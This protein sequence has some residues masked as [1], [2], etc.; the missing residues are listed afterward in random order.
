M[1]DRAWH[2]DGGNVSIPVL[3]SAPTVPVRVGIS[4]HGGCQRGL[5]SVPPA[6]GLEH[7]LFTAFKRD[8]RVLEFAVESSARAIFTSWSRYRTRPRRS[9]ASTVSSWGA[10]ESRYLL[11]WHCLFLECAGRGSGAAARRSYGICWH[12]LA[13]R[14]QV[15]DKIL[16]LGRQ[17]PRDARRVLQ[18]FERF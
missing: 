14:E 12:Q 15:R 9:V 10:D 2:G 1:Q 7:T 11:I 5:C 3:R 4:K 8:F 13:P 6:L 18:L 17:S 16:V